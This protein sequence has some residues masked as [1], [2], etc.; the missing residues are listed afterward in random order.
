MTYNTENFGSNMRILRKLNQVT[1]EE[2]AKA[3]NTTRSTISNYE[4]GHRQPD[5]EMVAQVAD[6]FDVSVD[7][8]L[9]RTTVKMSVRDEMV[10]KEL[11]K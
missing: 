11:E 3:L 6:F 7:Y 4:R 9:G 8:L 10:L 5:N 2:L 1:Q